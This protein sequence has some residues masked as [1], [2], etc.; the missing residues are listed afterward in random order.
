MVL[1]CDLINT[2]DSEAHAVFIVESFFIFVLLCLLADSPGKFDEVVE[3]K[4][5]KVVVE[6]KA[7]MTV[8]GTTVDFVEERLK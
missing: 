1:M 8:I 3:D 5:V 2:I 6:P 4:G 7:L